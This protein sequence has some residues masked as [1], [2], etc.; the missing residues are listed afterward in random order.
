MRE[1]LEILWRSFCRLLVRLLYARVEVMGLDNLP[2]QGPVIVCANHVN[3]LVDG[4]VVQSLTARTLRPVARKRLFDL[5]VIGWLLDAI[6]AV[7]VYSRAYGDQGQNRGG[8]ARLFEM[9]DAGEAVLI[10]PEGHSH[11][12]TQLQPIK[13]G[14]ARMVLEA[15]GHERAVPVV[16]PV[17]IT[18]TEPTRFRRSVLVQVGAPVAT[19]G[20]PEGAEVE[21]LTQRI[22]RRMESQLLGASSWEELEFVLSLAP[23]FELRQT[24]PQYSNHIA[25]FK[26]LL[27]RR[28]RLQ[29]EHP[30]LMRGLIQDLDEF[31]AQCDWYGIGNYELGVDYQPKMMLGFVARALSFT[32][33][34]VPIGIWGGI[35]NSLAW[36]GLCIGMR[37]A[38]YEAHQK[39]T[40]R[41]V[42]GLFMALVFWSAQTLV[43]YCLFESRWWAALYALSLPI[44]TVTLLLMR[45]QRYRIIGRI[46]VFWVF[47]WQREM[48]AYLK[49]RRQ[50]IEQRLAE[51]V[52]HARAL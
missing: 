42:G 46:K 31:S 26:L 7:P 40:A 15:R 49:R 39:D 50:R 3:S 51:A 13:T 10:F 52:R 34:A 9:I 2:E 30:E 35:N 11:H 43:V 28:H 23:F 29:S 25:S 27:S 8:F 18:Y 19:H 6:R 24:R 41:A 33:L 22:Q 45:E 48:Y 4:L 21:A 5:P 20:L 32:F 47:I 37:Y 36:L 12:R 14:A 38:R 16:I 1:H 17:G 44:S